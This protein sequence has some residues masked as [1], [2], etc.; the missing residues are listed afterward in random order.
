VPVVSLVV[1][2][3][4]SLNLIYTVFVASPAVSVHPVLA[5]QDC[6]LV[7]AAALPNAIC[8]HHTHVSVAH[9]VFNVTAVLVVYAALLF[10]VNDHQFG[11]VVS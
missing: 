6:R 3:N 10:I 5:D 2:P 11:G 4:T 8:T 1:F 7:G 9:V